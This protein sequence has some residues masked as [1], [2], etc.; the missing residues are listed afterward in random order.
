V[1]SAGQPIPDETVGAMRLRLFP[2]WVTKIDVEDASYIK[3]REVNLGVEL[4][5]SLIAKVWS[6]ARFVR[7]SV[8]GRNLLTWTNYTGADPEVSNN[9]SR[10]IRIGFDDIAPYPPSRTFW[11]NIDVGF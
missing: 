4:P 6:G 8:S 3:L 10:N 5:K 1:N 2:A 11:F 7:M 9:G